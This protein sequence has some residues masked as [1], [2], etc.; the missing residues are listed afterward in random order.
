MA[1]QG[2]SVAVITSRQLY[3]A[4]DE[5]LAPHEVVRGVAIHRVWTSRFGR[6]RLLGRAVDYATFYLAAAWRLWRLARAGEVVVAKTDP[7]MLSV[8]A[9]PICWLRRARLV[10]WLQDIFP[11]TA[12][13][14]GVGGHAA[15]AVY[16]LLRWLRNR[17]LGAARLNVAVGER[18][19]ERLIDFGIPADRVHVVPNW[20]DG[21]LI[22][23]IAHPSNGLR[24]Q[25]GLN[26]AFVVAYSGNLGRAHD[27]DTLLEAMTIVQRASTTSPAICRA[28]VRHRG[29]RRWPG[30]LS[31]VGHYSSACGPK[32]AAAASPRCTSSRTS[33]QRCWRR[34]SRPRTCISFRCGPSSKA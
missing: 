11:E 30:C 2:R 10:N 32:L 14:L 18:M 12:E 9:A 4:P 6:D 13:A 17:S 21:A 20:A 26:G 22:E 23:P 19:A 28:G 3:D 34:A 15:R 5:W 27:I 33:P 1:E 29:G 7:P 24:S 8:M 31:A 25:W 16:P